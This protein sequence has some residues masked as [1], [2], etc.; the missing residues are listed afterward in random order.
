MSERGSFITEFIYCKKCLDGVRTVLTGN[1]KYLNSI[2]IPHWNGFD[3]PH[4]IIAGKIGGL[5]PGEELVTF[6]YEFIP[7]IKEVI[8]HELRIAVVAQCGEKIFTIDPNPPVDYSLYKC[9][10]SDL[11]YDHELH[12]PEGHVKT[13][14]VWCI[15][16]FRGPVSYLGVD[17]L[18]LK[19]KGA[20]P[21]GPDE[22]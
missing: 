16:G 8:C 18:R 1:K 19:K 21:L 3:I 11:G 12:G 13:S 15:C 17:D 20:E 7:Q 4:P 6:E 14:W 10:Y 5:Y 2:E 22:K 9:P